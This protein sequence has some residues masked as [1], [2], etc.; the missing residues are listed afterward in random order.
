MR[1]KY[2]ATSPGRV[3]LILRP[4]DEFDV[5]VKL[6]ERL[7]AASPKLQEPTATATRSRIR[8]R[9]GKA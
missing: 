9:E 7:K 5:N 6:G 4:G 2:N 3:E 1:I 8:R